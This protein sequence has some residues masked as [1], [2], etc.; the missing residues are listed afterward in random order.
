MYISCT[1]IDFLD[2]TRTPPP[3]NPDHTA[4]MYPSNDIQSGSL[5]SYTEQINR[6]IFDLT[7]F[8]PDALIF[9]QINTDLFL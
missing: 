7:N 9:I 6:S 2:L 4:I 8:F 3:F 1:L 5:L